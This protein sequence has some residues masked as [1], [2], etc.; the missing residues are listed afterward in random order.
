MRNNLTSL[1]A[2]VLICG[3]AV[4][5]D[6]SVETFNAI[7]LENSSN[8]GSHVTLQA[9]TGLSGGG[10]S[11]TFPA[12]GPG[13]TSQR[14]AFSLNGSNNA[15]SWYPTPLGN[16]GQ[17]AYFS[18]LETVVSSSNLTWTQADRNLGIT[19]D[20]A[21]SMLTL[22]KNAN[23]SSNDQLINV[24][25]TYDSDQGRTVSLININADGT[26][27]GN[28]STINGLYID[29]NHGPSATANPSKAMGLYIDVSGAD[30]NR[31]AVF[32]GG[33]V[34]V[35]TDYPNVYLDVAGD[36]AYR[37]YN[38]TGNLGT[39]N[40]NVDFDGQNNRSSFIRIGTATSADITISGIKGGKDGKVLI[41]YN[42]TGNAIK[43]KHEGTTSDAAN[44]FRS[45]V[46]G[47]LQLLPGNS[48]QLIYSGYEQRWIIAFAGPGELENLGNKTVTIPGNNATLP[49]SIASYIQVKTPTGQTNYDLY[50]D[51]GVSPGQLL[52]VNNLGPK[53]I[54]F[55][56]TNIQLQTSHAAL[57]V[58]GSII[59][60]WNGVKWIQIA[61][62][63]Q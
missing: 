27:M 41:L 28:G 3:P 59:F 30:T 31:A 62:A 36:I 52:V 49:S 35:N 24:S 6:T 54:D 53:K 34:G 56:G 17:V 25:A 61:E 33:H 16:A 15:L 18:A 47:D 39:T 20:A 23:I 19:S 44:R 22:T 63:S 10:Y 60:V 51:N 4:A 55:V 57:D 48:Y 50:L 5:Q 32:K 46:S 13:N 9:P 8:P 14:W 42:A 26:A 58:G 2:L 1:V 12:T 37:E 43:I 7:R 21:G 45:G 40:N 11:L 29:I 38:F